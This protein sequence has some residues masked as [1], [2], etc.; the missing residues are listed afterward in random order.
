MVVLPAGTSLINNLIIFKHVRSSSTRIQ[1]L[2]SPSISRRDLHLL[3]HLLVMFCI[4]VGGWAPIYLYTNIHPSFHF[5]ETIVTMFTF[6]AELSVLCIVVDLFVY[7]RELT[8][9]LHG[10]ICGCY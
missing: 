8:N 5:T 9:H 6:A 2:A 3:R 10:L 4:F 7:N 1:P